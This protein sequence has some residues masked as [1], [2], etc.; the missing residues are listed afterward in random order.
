MNY[1]YANGTDNLKNV[2]MANELMAKVY[3][4][5]GYIMLVPQCPDGTWTGLDVEHGNYSVA[6]TA[7]ST[8]MQTVYGLI[9]DIEAK[10]QT[11]GIY[12]VGV[13]SGGYAVADL[14]AR[15]Q[16]LLSAAV[17]L[18]GAGDPS[19]DSG[20]TKVLIIHGEGDGKIPAD[21]ARSLADGWGAEYLEMSR[22]LHDCWKIAFQKEDILGW[23]NKN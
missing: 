23:L 19:A 6:N 4:D 18:A 15:H 3:A 10:Y 7:E 14:C 12:A 17:I 21:N 1:E 22:E 13:A 9:R 8:M 2:Q 16:G 11:A 5:G 20:N